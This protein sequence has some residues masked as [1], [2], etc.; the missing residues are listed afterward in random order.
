MEYKIFG[1][2][3]NKYYTDKWLLSD[4]LKGKDGIFV[5]S[6]VVTDSAK[7]KWI[8]FIKDVAN[9][10]NKNEKIYISGCGAFKEGRAQKDFFE[11]YPE[12]SEY[13]GVIEVLGE[14]PNPPIPSPF[15]PREK[16]NSKNVASSL[17]RGE[18]ERG[19]SEKLKTLPQLYTKKFVLIQGGCDSF[20]T[21]CLTVIK[22]GRHFSRTKEDIVSEILEFEKSGGKEVVLTG[23]NLGAWGLKSTNDIG[24]SRLAELL[25]YILEKTTIPR[26]RIS[27]LGPE[28]VD[29]A[30]LKIFEN[31]RIY[32]HFHLSIQ[33]G[34][35][36]ILKSMSRHY[37]GEYMRKLLEKFRNIKRED[38]VDISLGADII[39]GF[40]GE[41]EEDFLE[42]Y[43]LVKDY[44]I[45][46]LHAFPFSAHDMG[47]SVPAGKFKNQVPE[48]TKKDRMDRLLELG[49]KV[50]DEFIASQQGK[51]LHVLIE[52]VKSGTWKG[53]SENYIECNETNF[54][55]E[56]GKIGK[57]EIVTGKLF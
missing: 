43:N 15:P 41:T 47:E 13:K 31:S 6:C 40:P 57:N 48:K 35:S 44:K 25:E 22:R 23:I 26:I 14:D 20:C 17:P 5:A 49:D 30:C 37:D 51:P 52:V 11:I 7:R 8:K 33:S 16:G 2:K 9:G 46:K 21:F 39:V 10:L 18:T 45:T 32:P 54:K 1:C 19:I 27:S 34:S 36:S 42:T 28:F 12:L 38:G 3:V 56:S 29:E 24:D 53:W 55:I 4:Y 50:R